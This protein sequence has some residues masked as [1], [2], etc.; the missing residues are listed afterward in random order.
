MFPHE[1]G[2]T[3][4]GGLYVYAVCE[5]EILYSSVYPDYYQAGTVQT[6]TSVIFNMKEDTATENP[7]VTVIAAFVR[8]GSIKEIDGCTAVGSVS[9][10]N[11]EYSADTADNA[12]ANTDSGENIRSAKA[13]TEDNL[14]SADPSLYLVGESDSGIEFSAITNI[15]DDGYDTVYLTTN[16]TAQSRYVKFDKVYG[17]SEEAVRYY[18]FL[19]LDEILG[20]NDSDGYIIAAAIPRDGGKTAVSPIYRLENN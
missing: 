11:P 9:L 2:Y 20:E 3:D 15:C 4:Y 7:T 13:D 17:D 5:G 16:G 10:K 8:D 6:V 12:Y 19:S 14:R 18:A 1:D